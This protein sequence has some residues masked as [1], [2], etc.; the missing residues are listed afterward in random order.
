MKFCSDC[1]AK[2]DF[3]VPDGDNRPRFLCDHCG[4]IHYQNPR[5]VAGCI[6][7]WES[8]LLLCRRAIEPR[9]GL[10]TIPAGFMENG[11]TV[12]QAACRE[13]AEE[14]CADVALTALYAVCNIPRVDQVY[15]IFRASLIDGRF[16]PGEESLETE[17]FS[18]EE[19]PWTELAFPVVERTLRHFFDDRSRGRFE[20]YL[21]TI[22]GPGKQTS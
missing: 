22:P 13:T 12:E 11:E 16:R 17:L 18:E 3:R 2:V 7:E 21:D 4:S 5:I 19:I 8:Q 6:T 10:W 1:G 9:Y 15:M 20:T 14:A